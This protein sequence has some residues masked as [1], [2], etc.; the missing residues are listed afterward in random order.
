MKTWHHELKYTASCAIADEVFTESSIFFDIETTGFSPSHTSLYL[1]GCARR[2]GDYLCI[3]QFFAEHPSEEKLV[4]NAFIELL[5]QYPVI[6]SFNGIGFDIPYLKAKCD[7]YSINETFQEFEYLDIFKVI[8][9]YKFLFKLPNYKQKSVET[10]LGIEREDLY[11]GGQLISL[12][13]DYVKAPNDELLSLLKL[14]NYEDVLGMI[15]LLP[16]LSY[17]QL[18]E[19]QYTLHSIE[20]VP[21]TSMNQDET[22][23]DLLITLKN[24]FMIPKRVSCRYDDFYFT[25]LG[26]TAKINIRITEGEL[27]FFYPDPVNYY[28]LPKE[29]RAIH[30]SVASYVDKE[31]REKA[32]ASNCYSKKDGIFL[33]QF[34]EIVKPSFRVAYKDK[35]TYFE[36][37]DDFSESDILLRRYVNHILSLF[38]TNKK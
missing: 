12:Y 5:K 14:H 36:L 35:K 8:S 7:Q 16:I 37:T 25:A 6:I 22:G 4:L 11:D 20:C 17:P 10:F 31:F 15:D 24:D 21:F 1:I 28:F 32:K 23:T 29:D 30:K 26:D 38:K 3:D 33:P 9:K 18:F 13:H 34:E 19:G 2:K 27:K